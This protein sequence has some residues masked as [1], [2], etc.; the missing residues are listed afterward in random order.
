MGAHRRNVL[1][2]QAIPI[3][4]WILKIPLIY[5]PFFISCMAKDHCAL[6]RRCHFPL[7]PSTFTKRMGPLF[8]GRT[9]D[10]GSGI[11]TYMTENYE[12]DE[13]HI[14]LSPVFFTQIQTF[15]KSSFK[16]LPFLV[17]QWKRKAHKI[18]HALE[19]CVIDD[20][21]YYAP[22]ARQQ[23]SNTSS[24]TT[25]RIFPVEMKEHQDHIS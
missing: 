13:K 17:V 5:R 7:F 20:V 9:A 10:C 18:C 3:M 24:A 22:S 19:A 25:D 15:L 1:F 12:H 23:R 21:S 16:P 6:A 8:F 11:Y 2:M 4:V 14:C